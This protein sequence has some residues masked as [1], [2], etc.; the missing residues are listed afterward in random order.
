MAKLNPFTDKD[1]LQWNKDLKEIADLEELVEAAKELNLPSADVMKD[2]C[3]GC[4]QQ[5]HNLKA[6]F[7]PGKP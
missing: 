2:R 6:R 1:R 5:I 3:E 4:K 7:F